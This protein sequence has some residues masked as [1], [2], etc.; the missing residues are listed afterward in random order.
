MNPEIIE[1]MINALT[2]EE[3]IELL[4]DGETLFIE[5]EIIDWLCTNRPSVITKYLITTNSP[6]DL[7]LSFME[8]INGNVI[9]R[10]N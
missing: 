6:D 2:E 10:T 8:D 7:D 9:S 1:K 3:L 4:I 5:D